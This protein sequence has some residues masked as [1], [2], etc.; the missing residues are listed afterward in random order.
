MKFDITEDD[1][2]LTLEINTKTQA[3]L[4]IQGEQPQVVVLTVNQLEK[5]CE[6]VFEHMD[7]DEVTL[8][9]TDNEEGKY[10]H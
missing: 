8:I 5:L 3:L 6:H 7:E 9:E 4:L 10:V 1:L 2:D